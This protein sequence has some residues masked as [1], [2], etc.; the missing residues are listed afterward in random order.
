MQAET[1]LSKVL[2]L[3]ATFNGGDYLTEQIQSLRN[4]THSNWELLI[5]DDCSTDNT[6]DIIEEFTCSDSRIRIIPNRNI[7]LGACLNFSELM[8][9]VDR[10][11][12]IMFCDQDDIWMPDKIEKSLASIKDLEKHHGA[13]KCLMVYGTYRLINE[14]GDVLP[15]EAPDYS[16]QPS[17]QLLLSQNYLYGCTMMINKNLLKLASPI[18]ITAENHD[19]WIA[20]TALVNDAK[21]AYIKEPLLFYR[22]HSQNVSGSYANAFFINRIKRLISKSEIKHLINRLRMLVSLSERFSSNMNDDIK[23]LLNGQI[24]ALQKGG[25]YAVFY[26]VKNSIGR[27]GKA[28][29]ALY[30]FNLLRMKRS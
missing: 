12:Y 18:P 20:L 14:M 30:Y 28:Q 26:N 23:S 29:T 8:K 17:L 1:Q 4:Q 13:D 5:R 7:N 22:Q 19:Y 16:V 2:I 6:L 27:M 15:L 24:Q 3:M 21:I 9:E 11:D 10:G 25:L